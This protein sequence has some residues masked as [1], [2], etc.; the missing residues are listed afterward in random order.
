MAYVRTV[1][2]NRYTVRNDDE[3]YKYTY[4]RMGFENAVQSSTILAVVLAGIG[5][6][7]LVMSLLF[8]SLPNVGLNILHIY[9]GRVLVC[10]C[11]VSFGLAVIFTVLRLMWIC[12]MADLDTTHTVTYGQW[13]NRYDGGL[14]SDDVQV[15]DGQE[16][17]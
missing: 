17:A 1:R 7:T 13:R 10:V 8:M 12:G 5:M 16:D 14:V 9:A 15:S 11:M 6:L 3:I 2:K 4:D